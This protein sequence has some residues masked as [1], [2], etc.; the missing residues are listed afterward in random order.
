MVQRLIH[1]FILSNPTIKKIDY[2][3]DTLDV[4]IKNANDKENIL[5]SYQHEYEKNKY[6]I[7]VKSKGSE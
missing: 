3:D 7:K 2:W 5:E 1:D 4:I 6:K